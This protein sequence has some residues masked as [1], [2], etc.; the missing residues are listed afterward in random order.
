M[1]KPRTRVILLG[2]GNPNPDPRHSGPSLIILVGE[3]PYVVDF[4]A[5]L[6]RQAAAF[7]PEYGGAI[8]ELDIKNLK[9]A[10]LTHLH[11]DHTIGYPDLILTP[12]VMGRDAPLEV[13]GPK[14]TAALTEHILNAYRGD[15]DYRLQGLE[16]VNRQGWRVN[17]HEIGEGIIYQDGNV[18][19]EAFLVKHGTMPNAF[20]F[21][22][23]TPDKVIVVS[24]DTSPCENIVSYALGAD[25]LIHEVY[26]QGAFDQKD[27]AWQKY[28]ST[29][30]T[31]TRELGEIARKTRPELLVLYH[32][33]FWGASEDDLLAEIARDYNS[34]V[35]VGS[36]LLVIE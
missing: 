25:I 13:F 10:F 31:S 1:N 17:A 16:P 3:T 14:G 19:V 29:H 4:G 28:H 18:K 12:W 5:G 11:S 21:R 35:I 20:G 22:F 9:T 24:G 6:V 8:K 34:K 2:T 33:L 26:Y 32:T 27:A 15:I 36:D 23:T 7:T 30:H